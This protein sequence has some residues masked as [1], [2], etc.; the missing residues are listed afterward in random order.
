M[1]QLPPSSAST[2]RSWPR[3]SIIVGISPGVHSG[4]MTL[5]LQPHDLA[6]LNEQVRS[7][8]RAFVRDLQHLV[9]IDSG[10]FTKSEVDRVS[11]WMMERLEELGAT[12]TR[13]PHPELGD[14]LV[15][16]LERSAPGPTVLL[17]GHA[18]TV[19]E[20]GTVTER[21]FSIDGQRALGPGV[22]DMKS[23]L[24]CGLYALSALRGSIQ[25]VDGWLPVGRVMFVVNPDEEIGSPTSTPVIRELSAGA[26]AALVLEGA[27]PNGDIVSSRFGMMHLRITIEGRAAH[28]GVEPENGRSAVLEAAHLTVRLS[29]LADQ[30]EGVSINV[31]EIHGGTRPNI[32]P[33]EAT[34]VVDVRARTQVEQDE[35]ERAIGALLESSTIPDTRTSL[36]VQARYRPMEH[37]SR[38][39]RL[40]DTAIEVAAG[41]DFELADTFSRGSSDGNTTAGAGV[42]T[43]DGLGAVGGNRHAPGEYLELESIVPRTAWLAAMLAEIGLN[44]ESDR[45]G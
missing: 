18:D 10:T 8:Y 31:G 22:A 41:L 17:L 21:P 33:A 19:F 4:S 7:S 6:G 20:V 12:V 40:V 25:D 36:E 24:L 27:R 39:Q 9:D 5:D 28:A 45:Q 13:H 26:D 16:A 29:Q 14:T 23:G 38:S 2:A 42:P 34:M 43:L 35:A 37:S 11:G 15:A 1:P 30:W 44:D 32:V 3:S